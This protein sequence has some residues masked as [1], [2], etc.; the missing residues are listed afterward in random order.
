[1]GGELK[2]VSSHRAGT[3]ITAILPLHPGAA[4]LP[5]SPDANHQPVVKPGLRR[6]SARPSAKPIV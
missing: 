3:T 2:I 1:M 6:T 4:S 5:P